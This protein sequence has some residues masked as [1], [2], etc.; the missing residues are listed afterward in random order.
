MLVTLQAFKGL[1]SSQPCS[2]AALVFESS[3]RGDPHVRQYFDELGLLTNGRPIP[4]EHRFMPKSGGEPGL[5]LAD[6]VAS[7]AGSQA[8]RYLRGE[9]GFAKDYQ[10]VFHQF[11]PPFSHFFHIEEVG[12]SRES[13]EAWVQGFRRT[14]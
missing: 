9:T 12:G 11:P 2:T 10:D 8:R 13:Q 1:V 7:A 5:Q 6:F 3:K 4:T 14:E